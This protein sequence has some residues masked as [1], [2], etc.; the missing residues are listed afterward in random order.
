MAGKFWNVDNELLQA[1]YMRILRLCDPSDSYEKR[2]DHFWG[3]G[4]FTLGAAIL[5]SPLATCEFLL[6]ESHAMLTMPM[7]HYRVADGLGSSW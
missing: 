5:P 2:Y 4:W 7:Q 6:F 3:N 1:F